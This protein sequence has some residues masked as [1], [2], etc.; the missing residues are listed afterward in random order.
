MSRAIDKII[1]IDGDNFEYT[2][3]LWVNGWYAVTSAD[4]ASLSIEDTNHV[5]VIRGVSALA[6]ERMIYG[7]PLASPTRIQ[8][9][10]VGVWTNIER[11]IIFVDR[12]SAS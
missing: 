11:V 5:A 1:E 12:F 3:V 8:N 7:P 10:K 2:G 4:T 9:L 6:N